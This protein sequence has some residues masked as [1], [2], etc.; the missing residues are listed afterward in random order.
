MDAGKGAK[1][2]AARRGGKEAGA[3]FCG[4]DGVRDEPIEEGFDGEEGEAGGGDDSVEDGFVLF[5]LERAGG[6]DDAAAGCEAAGG[7][8]QDFISGLRARVPVP[9]QGTS[10]R[11]RSKAAEANE[12]GL[13]ASVTSQRTCRA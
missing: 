10:Q 1:G 3:D 5:R 12:A 7:I 11:M 9:L 8:G 4:K 2:T 13:D 6:V